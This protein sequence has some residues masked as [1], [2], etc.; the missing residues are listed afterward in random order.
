MDHLVNNAGVTHSFLFSD[1]A[2]MKGLTA[3]M[4]KIILLLVA[5]LKKFQEPRE[6][7]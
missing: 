7:S 5:C 2:D 4:V 6:F 3:T 1:T